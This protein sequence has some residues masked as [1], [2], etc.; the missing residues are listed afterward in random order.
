MIFGIGVDLCDVKRIEK[1]YKNHGQKFVQRIL[2]A[3]EIEN[4][5]QRKKSMHFL[6]LRF[7]AKEATVKAL[8]TGFSQGIGFHQVEISNLE[9]GKPVVG[10]TGKAKSVMQDQNITSC[11]LSLSDEK[12][13]VVA[14]VVLEK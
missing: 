4:F 2:T 1:V 14:M 5:N 11:Y 12:S 8:G 10:L 6:A 7:A 9:S 3:K 13:H